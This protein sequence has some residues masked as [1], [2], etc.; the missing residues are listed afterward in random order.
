MNTGE[1]SR[2]SQSQITQL[3][4]AW[5]RTRLTLEN[6]LGA[7]IRTATALIAFGFAIVQF[8][9]R[10]NHMEGVRPPSDPELPRFLGLLLIA[11]GTIALALVI[12]QYQAVIKHLRSEEFR[13]CC[14]IPGMRRLYPSIA[15]AVM[16]CAIGALIFF[17][18]LTR[19]S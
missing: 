10:F 1:S 6:T 5:L 13:H 17:I 19:A 7:W 14:G 9:E 16:L 2:D 4:F 15:V 8:F 3:H 18:I 12:W 11:V